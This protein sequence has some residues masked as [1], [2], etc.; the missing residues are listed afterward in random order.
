MTNSSI[1]NA[2]H[3]PFLDLQA[4]YLELRPDID[5]AIAA[6]LARGWFILGDEVRAFEK[7]FAAYCGASHCIGVS[8]GLDAL[9]LVLRAWDIGP[10]DEVIVPSNTFIATW[11]AV[12]YAGATPVPVEPDTRTYN[13]D[14]ARIEAAITPATKAIIPVH[15]YGQPAD[16]DPILAIARS[17]GLK[18]LEDAAQAHGARYRGRPAGSLGDAAAWSFYPGKNLGAMGDGGAVTTGDE[19]LASR[20]RELANYGSSAKYVHD[21]KGFNCRLDELQAAVLRV[22]LRALDQW[23]ERRRALAVFYLSEL[24]DMRLDL[25]AVHDGCDP[26]WHLFVVASD[27]R[28]ALQRALTERSVDT[29]IHYPQPPFAQKAYAEMESAGARCPLATA[30]ARRVLSLPMGPHVSEEQ[31]RTV[32]AAVRGALAVIR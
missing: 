31:A 5:A 7:E 26:V 30:I 15:L 16:L 6:V 8:N 27:D 4:P 3:V 25:P 28:D 24:E 23:N 2:V 19:R 12:S 21:E 1:S 13:L 29:L 14:P 22:K 17:H 9:H 10:G 20:V 11:L 18:V 32:V